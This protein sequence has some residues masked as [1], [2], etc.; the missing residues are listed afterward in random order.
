MKEIKKGI[1]KESVL[2]ANNESGSRT[3]T[4]I[5]RLPRRRRSGMSVFAAGA[6]S[7]GLAALA[8]AGSF[9]AEETRGQEEDPVRV[10]SFLPAESDISSKFL[11]GMQ[12]RAD[13]EEHLEFSWYYYE[14]FSGMNF[15]K[16][17]DTA[18]AMQKDYLI[19][20]GGTAEG[21]CEEAIERMKESSLQL[22]VID[23]D[24]EN[25]EDR[26]AFVGTDNREAGVQII[27]DVSASVEHPCVAVFM[28]YTHGGIM[29]RQSGVQEEAAQKQISVAVTEVLSE[30]VISARKEIEQVLEHNAE[31]NTVV[32]LD[33]SSSVAAAQVMESKTENRPYTACFDCEEAVVNALKNG[34]IDLIMMQDYAQMGRVSIEIAASGDAAGADSEIYTKCIPIT[35]ENIGEI[36]G[37]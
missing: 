17:V 5:R 23:H 12:E 1:R 16:C 8:A 20:F 10:V 22:I 11:Q 37:E 36:Y 9:C 6:L 32:C 28:T 35:A 2:P 25:P 30:N 18:I 31:I 34:K 14:D 7:F 19:S 21:E 26:R 3:G 33:G 13:Q 29:D 4:D 24:M 27:D 15:E